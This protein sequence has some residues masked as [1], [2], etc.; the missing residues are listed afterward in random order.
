MVRT[1]KAHGGRDW[2]GQVEQICIQ[3]GLQLTPTRRGVLEI[4]AAS[5]APQGAYALMDQLSKTQGR[6]IAPPTVYRALEFL[7]EHGFRVQDRQRQRFRALLTISAITITD[8][9]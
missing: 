2:I 5:R 1:A 7:V 6:T 3:R 8:C 4:L 9:C